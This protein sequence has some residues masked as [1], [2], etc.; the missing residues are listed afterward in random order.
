MS[1]PS[2]VLAAPAPQ[3]GRPSRFRRA[4]PVAAIIALS[5]ILAVVASR[6]DSVTYDELAHL[7]AGVSYL[8]TH[9]F[10]MDPENPP[11]SSVWA[12]LPVVMTAYAWP[13]DHPDWV[14]G[15]QWEFARAWFNEHN[16]GERLLRRARLMMAVL[17]GLTL[18]ATYRLSRALFGRGAALLTLTLAAFSPLLLAHGVLVTSDV[19]VTLF[20]VC[21]LLTFAAVLKR[22]TIVRFAGCAA[23]VVC[24][25]LTKY[26]GVLIAPALVVMA[27]ASRIDGTQRVGGAEILRRTGTA[28]LLLLGLGAGGYA[29]IWTAY[30]FRYSSFAP[31]DIVQ[32]PVADS[33]VAPTT[34]AATADD[35]RITRGT[36]W[37]MALVDL[38]QTHGKRVVADVI[39]WARDGRLLPEAYLYGF[40]HTVHRAQARG[41]YLL[42]A[43]STT[44]W[45]Y[46]FPVAYGLKT[47]IVV[48]AMIVGGLWSIA[49]SKLWG[50][51]QPVLWAGLL[52]FSLIYAGVAARGHLNIGLRHMLPAYPLLLVVGG[53]LALQWS[54]SAVRWVV[55]IGCLWL[56]VANISVFPHYLAYFNEFAGGPTRGLDY[57]ADSNIDWGQDLVRLREYVDAHP[58]ETI[59]LSYFG[60][61]DHRHYLDA[62]PLPSGFETGDVAPI[63]P[64]TYAISVNELLGLYDPFRRASSWWSAKFQSAFQTVRQQAFP[65]VEPQDSAAR[66][67]MLDFRRSYRR[68]RAERLIAELRSRR[69]SARVGYS[70][71]LFKLS[72]ADLA[73]IESRWR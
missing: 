42:G 14:A 17:L 36:A 65:T 56:I 27:I 41:A 71:L 73:R 60:S 2:N 25:A 66:R 61:V 16:D 51:R 22:F 30:G 59:Y 34:A 6:R 13:D 64:G 63:G 39:R 9:D 48:M 24:L 47:P 8:H 3:R 29:G 40:T 69:P 70:I 57:L 31:V 11:L 52:T 44:G 54:S 46:Y 28:T 67:E 72:A 19:P 5:L 32:T 53:T 10:R 50:S 7:T 58:D 12:A 43:Y 45:W 20:A 33:G 18:W 37:S 68:V 1:E 21:V 26:S 55:G 15:H 4:L 49:R 62:K 35:C 23:C 38:E